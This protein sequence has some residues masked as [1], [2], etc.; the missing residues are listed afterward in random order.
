MGNLERAF[1]ALKTVE[2]ETRP[3][4]HKVD[5]RIQAHLFLCMLAYYVQWHMQKRLAPLFESDG[6]GADRRWSFSGVIECLKNQGHH[7]MEIEKVTYEQDGA[8]D[9][10]QQKIM[11]LLSTDI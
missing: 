1:R 10:D 7:E 5:R 8:C 3:V 2:L 11:D 6:K 9:P 4:H